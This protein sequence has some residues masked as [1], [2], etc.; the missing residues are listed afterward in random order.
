ML[1]LVTSNPTFPG[2]V[3]DNFIK[4]ISN[5]HLSTKSQDVLLISRRVLYLL[6]TTWFLEDQFG[7]N[8]DERIGYRRYPYEMAAILGLVEWKYTIEMM[9][10]ANLDSVPALD[11]DNQSADSILASH[12]SLLWGSFDVVKRIMSM[13]AFELLAMKKY[14]LD[15]IPLGMSLLPL[16]QQTFMR[17]GDC[18]Y[19]IVGMIQP[20]Q[21]YSEVH[22]NKSF[23]LMILNLDIDFLSKPFDE[24]FVKIEFKDI[25]LD[26]LVL[27]KFS[28]NNLKRS[29]QLITLQEF[30][31]LVKNGISKEE[32]I[33]KIVEKGHPE[34]T[35]ALAAVQDNSLLLYLSPLSVPYAHYW[36]SKIPEISI[37]EV[38]TYEFNFEFKESTFVCER[39]NEEDYIQ[40]LGKSFEKI[41]NE[42]LRNAILK[43]ITGKDH[44]NREFREICRDK[45]FQEIRILSEKIDFF[46]DSREILFEGKVLNCIDDIVALFDWGLSALLGLVDWTEAIIEWQESFTKLRDCGEFQPEA[47]AY[48]NWF[49]D[50]LFEKLTVSNPKNLDGASSTSQ[51]RNLIYT[52]FLLLERSP[53]PAEIDIILSSLKILI[54]LHTTSNLIFGSML[55][56][57]LNLAPEGSPIWISR[58]SSGH[59][60]AMRIIPAFDVLD[61]QKK[62]FDIRIFNTGEDSSLFHEIHKESIH[63]RFAEYAKVPLPLLSLDSIYLNTDSSD[64]EAITKG[65]N[66]D[67][68]TW[69]L[70][71]D[72]HFRVARESSKVI[73][74]KEFV[75]FQKRG[76][77]TAR[78]LIALFKSELGYENY[79]LWKTMIGIAKLE[80]FAEAYYFKRDEDLV[81]KMY[82]LMLSLVPESLDIKIAKYG[83]RKLFK[84]H[85]VESKQ[86]ALL[87][88][89]KRTK[90]R[91]SDRISLSL[92]GPC[93]TDYNFSING[94]LFKA[95]DRIFLLYFLKLEEMEDG[96]KLSWGNN[97][98]TLEV[99]INTKSDLTR[100]EALNSE[101]YV[102]IDDSI[103]ATYESP[104]IQKCTCEFRVVKKLMDPFLF[105][106]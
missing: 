5:I 66:I 49:G 33:L 39:I 3:D 79:K 64:T 16:H 34:I 42:K 27:R 50:S 21:V 26:D 45:S 68:F 15:Y 96:L 52:S 17:L 41:A 67:N 81:D 72:E 51:I 63:L 47:R 10:T 29:M 85:H 43:N 62:V 91:L 35:S 6:R 4:R 87:R 80:T 90:A 25:S 71:P 32:A 76:T 38:A 8:A 54:S 57:L 53:S 23:N 24:S 102:A 1:N 65:S 44:Q 99:N 19:F 101:A 48:A 82:E 31:K 56:N 70:Y 104:S 60:T 59:E 13:H 89:I 18:G 40:N 97:S 78:S 20:T 100:G 12:A 69:L 84:E 92:V 37:Q 28:K 22:I 2:W 86:A 14:I 103:T 58:N 94:T 77:C 46:H 75:K 36:K 30:A 74:Q 83:K 9:T 106:K 61:H 11:T 95:K 73:D 7:L 105:N 93:P 88:A 55:L 98:G